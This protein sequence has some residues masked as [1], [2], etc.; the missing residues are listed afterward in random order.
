M[1]T[2]SSNLQVLDIDHLGIVAGI[3]DEIRIVETVN[4]L[5][6]EHP[7]EQVSLGQVLKAMILNA[8]GFVSAPLY[9]FEQFFIGK[10]T[11][12]LIGVGVKPEH[13]NDDRLGR[14]LDKFY[15][16]GVTELFTAIAM[17]GAQTYE[18]ALGSA[19][20]DSSSF[21]VSGEYETEVAGETQQGEAIQTCEDP[22]VIN[23]THGYSRDHRPDLKQFLVDLVSSTDG[24]VPLFLRL[25]SGNEADKAVFVQVI[26]E[27][28][29]QWHFEG[30]FVVDSALFSAENLGQLG[31]IKWLTRVPLT[32]KQAKQVLRE[33]Q[34]SDWQPTEREGY[35]F[36]ECR[37]QYAS[38]EQRWIVI[39]SEKR[40]QADLKQSQKQIDQQS[41]QQQV[42]LQKL[43]HQSFA[44]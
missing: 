14:S 18:V 6:G 33:I 19:H 30:L 9:M 40:R 34:P 20:L 17:K 2:P 4:E 39:E 32:L 42:R 43:C 31:S 26:Q 36:V 29:K 35:R 28:R 13:L 3:I 15:Q 38:I 25:G 21:C 41:A 7:Q 16:Y 11:E 44:C 5:L 10:A 23:I 27:Y 1:N 24:D 12:H 22:G 8:L 37:R